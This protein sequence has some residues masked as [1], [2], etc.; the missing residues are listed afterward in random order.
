MQIGLVPDFLL[1][2]TRV[3][4]T[5][6]KFKVKR[7]NTVE[8]LYILHWEGNSSR[9]C[10]FWFLLKTRRKI[11]QMLELRPGRLFNFLSREGGAYLMGGGGRRLFCFSNF[12]LNITLSLFQANANGNIN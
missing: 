12:S 6:R 7:I 10:S 3:G 4:V 1:K 9:T 5:H 8:S 2:F 11:P